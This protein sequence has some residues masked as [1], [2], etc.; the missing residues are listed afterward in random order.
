[1]ESDVHKMMMKMLLTKNMFV[2]SILLVAYI[3]IIV[4]NCFVA[5]MCEHTQNLMGELFQVSGERFNMWKI[6]RLN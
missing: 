1:M 2:Y 5:H 6:F 3:L 4:M